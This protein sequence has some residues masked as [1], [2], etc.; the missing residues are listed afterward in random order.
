MPE[1]HFR[2]EEDYHSP[3]KFRKG[4]GGLCTNNRIPRCRNPVLPAPILGYSR[5]S[6]LS[7]RKKSPSRCPVWRGTKPARGGA[8]GGDLSPLL[9][10]QRSSQGE[11]AVGDYR[12]THYLCQLSTLIQPDSNSQP[13]VFLWASSHM[14]TLPSR[15]KPEPWSKS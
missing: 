13:T 7:I 3:K 6:M 8:P 5:D 9:G 15:V 12:V 4:W 10:G 11:L 14:A 1:R 2:Q